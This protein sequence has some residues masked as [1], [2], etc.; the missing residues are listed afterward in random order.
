MWIP[1]CDYHI[2]EV[3]NL[4]GW[5]WQGK[6]TDLDIKLLGEAVRRAGHA[7]LHYKFSNGQESRS[8]KHEFWWSKRQR[9][10]P[11]HPCSSGFSYRRCEL[12]VRTSCSSA[13]SHIDGGRPETELAKTS[14]G[15]RISFPKSYLSN[16]REVKGIRINKDFLV[17]SNSS[18]TIQRISYGHPWKAKNKTPCPLSSCSPFHSESLV[19]ISNWDILETILVLQATPFLFFLALLPFLLENLSLS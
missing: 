5:L 7:G 18:S 15:W 6:T 14:S 11:I 12:R 19:G 1:A 13:S 16:L 3:L 17:W 10:S 2:I 8:Q 4:T 9:T